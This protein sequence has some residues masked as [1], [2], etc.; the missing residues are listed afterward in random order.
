LPIKIC[1][2]KEDL[3]LLLQKLNPDYICLAGWKQIILDEVID[4]F[5][6]RILNLHPGLIPDNHN[7]DGTLGLWNRG[8]LTDKAIKNFID[9]KATNAGSSIHFLTKEFDFGPVLGRC[10]EK[11]QPG[12]TVDS[13]YTRLKVKENQLY[14]HVLARLCKNLTTVLITDG[15]GR[16]AALVDK[17][18]QSEQVEKILAV[19]GNDLMQINT[20]KKVVTF[21]H[22]KTTSI[23]E[24]LEICKK[25]KVD[26]VDVAQDNAVAVGLTDELMK[27]GIKVFGP[28][29]EAGQIEW[30]KAWA[31]EFMKKYQ[32]PSPEYH[33]FHSEKDG[34][35]FVKKYSK[36][37]FV[38]AAGLAEGKGVIPAENTQEAISAI[39]QMQ[40]FGSSGKTYLLEEWLVGEEFSAFVLCDGNDFK[41]VGYAQ[42][43][44][45]VFDGDKGPNTGGM[46]CVSNPLIVNTSIK[47]QVSS[48]MEK[49]IRGLRKEGR[50]YRGVL[51]LGGMVV[52]NKV[53]VIEFNARWGDPEAQVIIPAIKND[54][55]EIS[56]A[57]NFGKLKSLKIDVDKKVRV[58][59]AATSKGYPVDYSAAKDKKV[60][61]VEK[62]IKK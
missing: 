60:F 21:P 48:I 27:N 35:N 56:D 34:I 2:K 31:R 55:L 11:I 37:W 26:L 18:G 14:V 15:G 50:V 24:I 40:K 49:A 23:K 20:K 53:Y 38:K 7:P 13:L 1:P 12:D 44:K 30:D 45:R 6:N 42:D 51:Y 33:V 10:F 59:V 19:P 8:Q 25:E 28:T 58:V 5:P 52:N 29:K 47:Y 46:G 61:G 57:V 39:G 41:I 22:L 43:H 3:L 4:A 32:L 17:Y 36:A 9:S 62:A 54:F 16:G